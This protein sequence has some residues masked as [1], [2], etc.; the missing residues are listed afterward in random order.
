MGKKKR[1]KG[2]S[3]TASK[4]SALTTWVVIGSPKDGRPRAQ[5]VVGV[6]G[7][8]LQ[9]FDDFNDAIKNAFGNDPRR[10]QKL[11]C[12]NIEN[13]TPQTVSP[14]PGE[15]P[16][17]QARAWDGAGAGRRHFHGRPDR[18]EQRSAPGGPN[19][20]EH[21]VTL[22]G[23]EPDQ[24]GLRFKPHHNDRRDRPIKVESL[25]ITD[26]FLA[27]RP[28]STF[29]PNSEM[30]LL[31]YAQDVSEGLAGKPDIDENP[32]NF[33][34]WIAPNPSDAEAPRAA[35]HDE[36]RPN[37]LSG[38]IEVEFT[39]RTP[40][41]V[42]VGEIR[43]QSSTVTTEGRSQPQDFFHCW[44]GNCERY[45]IPGASVKGIVRSLFETLTNSR[46]G[47][48]DESALGNPPLYRRRAYQLFKITKLPSGAG[49]PGKV[50][51]CDYGLHDDAGKWNHRTNRL[52]CP[53][54]G[55]GIQETNFAAN[56]FWVDPRNHTHR[57]KK[58]RYKP[59]GKAFELHSDTIEHFKSMKEHPHLEAHG[60]SSGNAANASRKSYQLPPDFSNV[61]VRLFEL[62]VGDLIFG[63]PRNGR[64]HCFGRNVNFLWPAGR[65]AVGM[66]GKFS[67]RAPDM[68]KL[69]GSD[70]AEATF[71]FA[72]THRGDSH[73]FRGRVRFGT[74]WSSLETS[75]E[76]REKRP[77]LQLMPLTSPSGTKAKARPLYLNPG[78][79]G[80]S[81]DY[82]DD[83]AS[84]RGRKFYWHQKSETDNV[85]L[86]HRFDELSRSV[87]EVWKEKI[88]S[89]LPAPIRRLPAGTHFN[90][91]IHFSN[92]TCAELGA[93]LV[94]VKPDLAFEESDWKETPRYGIKIGKGKPRGLGSV[95]SDL[96]L[97]IVD[98]PPSMYRSLDAKLWKAPDNDAVRR[99]VCSYKK[100]MTSMGN[101]RLKW[102]DLEFAKALRKLLRLPDASSARVYPP[103]FMMY[104]WLPEA[105]DPDGSPRGGRPRRPT[106][107]TPAHKMNRTRG[108]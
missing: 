100:W 34:P 23:Y 12:N 28:G 58:I 31:Q 90:G 76:E 71:G 63:I 50:E 61:K 27:A 35:T 105:N 37:R 14:K 56:L 45:A 67:A 77:C 18:P 22:V 41:F 66:M 29:N 43:E 83:N 74:F 21:R 55:N 38:A 84:L 70:P 49:K 15:T 80:K 101:G 91:R 5:I 81:T 8:K 59:N 1:H 39:A 85:P 13:P 2:A 87:P 88:E 78:D 24:E 104:G 26:R 57:W 69:D 95:T 42:P 103:Q 7:Q 16:Q 20:H 52:P 40:V 10:G 11:L 94:S 53:V 9:S 25:K 19:R 44:D 64:L 65:T 96:T 89:Q 68:S 107:M 79:S 6:H 75:R 30:E 60:G 98:L 47:V 17:E 99:L 108:Q 46:A 33:A 106:A 4:E 32:Y 97:R 102:N 82:D 73:P 93:L 62:K 92:L 51:Q 54:P 72:G 86:V 48:T 3:T 36:M